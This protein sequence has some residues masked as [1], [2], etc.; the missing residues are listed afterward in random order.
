MYSGLLVPFSWRFKLRDYMSTYETIL[1]FIN[2][3]VDTWSYI[4]QYEPYVD[5]WSFIPQSERYANI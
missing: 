3:Y 2:P 5:M 1:P 4:V